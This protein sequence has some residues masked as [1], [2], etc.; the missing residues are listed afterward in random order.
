MNCPFVSSSKWWTQVASAL[1]VWVRNV[2]PLV[3][4]CSNNLEQM[5]FLSVLCW[6][7][8]P[9]G[10][11]WLSWQQG[12]LPQHLITYHWL[13]PLW[14]AAAVELSVWNLYNFIHIC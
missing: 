10:F 11:H 12:I 4:K 7:V 13:T 3:L 14:D 2:S 5:A 6:T 9:R 1:T 8:R